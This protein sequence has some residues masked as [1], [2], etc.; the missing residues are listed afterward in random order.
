MRYTYKL[1][2]PNGDEEMAEETYDSREAAEYAAL[3]DCGNFSLGGEIMSMMGDRDEDI[4][5]GE[6]RFKIIKVK[7]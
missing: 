3:D 5:R 1:I 6:C 4:I 7:D 2:Y